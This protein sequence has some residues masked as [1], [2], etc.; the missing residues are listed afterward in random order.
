MSTGKL[1][2]TQHITNKRPPQCYRCIHYFGK[3]KRRRCKAFPDADIPREYLFEKVKHDLILGNQVGDYIYEAKDRFK[4]GDK[5]Q[6]LEREKAISK[7]EINKKKLPSIIRERIKEREGNLDS[8]EKLEI[9]SS[10]PLSRRFDLQIDFFPKEEVVKFEG[11]QFDGMEIAGQIIKALE[12]K[13]LEPKF[14]LTI[15]KNG[16]YQYE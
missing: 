9:I 11:F 7:L 1:R 5:K 16:D 3:G 8:I 10:G 12:A 2:W 6:E 14:K 15:F 13:N 4:E